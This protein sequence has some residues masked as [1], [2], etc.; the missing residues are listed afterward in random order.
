MQNLSGTS[1]K[2]F[3][4]LAVDQSPQSFLNIKSNQW[5]LKL[6]CEQFAKVMDEQDPL[7]YMRAEF[8]YPKMA[9]L[10]KGLF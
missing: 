5:Q 8:F 7:G 10:P 1:N 3:F 6:N 4:R 2:D 9:T